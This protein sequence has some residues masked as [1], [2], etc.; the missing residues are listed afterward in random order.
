MRAMIVAAGLGTRLRPLTD[1]LPK[2]AVPVRGI[3]MIET[4]L[5]LLAAA[6]ARHVAVN[7]H[8]LPD[9]L[10]QVAEDACPAGVDLHFSMEESLLHTGGAIRRVAG[11]L[12][13]EETCLLVGGDMIVDLDLAGLVARHRRSGREVTLALL[14]RPDGAGSAH[15]TIGVDAEGRI[16][17][18][19]DR[20]D[21]GG[22]R[23][24][25]FYT[26]VNVVSRSAFA[27]LPARDVFNHLDDWWVPRAIAAPGTIG[28]ELLTPGDPVERPKRCRWI[29]VGTPAEY[30]RA[31]ASPLRLSYLDVDARA[32]GRGARLVGDC[33][34]GPGAVLGAGAHLR[35][36]VVWPDERVPAGF[37]GADGVYAGGTFH[38]FGREA[39]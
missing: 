25:G 14:R 38:D 27:T 30:L 9:R 36:A 10:R 23:G 20:W 21:A 24:A 32:A 37:A 6:G 33:V 8:H 11:F 39:A 26:W 15:G 16:C 17:R 22:E 5:A 31:N 34:V 19:A 2:P 35:R 12:G 1:L 4:T 18:V 29:P 3:P 28:A 7:L 13:E